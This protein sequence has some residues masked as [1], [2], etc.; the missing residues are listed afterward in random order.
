MS[1]SAAQSAQQTTLANLQTAFN[2][3]SNA[4]ARYGAFAVRAEA[5]GY[6]QVASLFRATSRAEQIHAAHHAK[7]IRSMGA[8]PVLTLE[9][10]DV[11]TTAENLKAAIA[12]EE[13]EHNVMYPE[14]IKQAEA[15]KD[16][17]AARTFKGAMAAE[18]EHAKLYKAALANLK[19]SAAKATYYVCPVCGFT[20]DKVT[21]DNCPV[22][23]V[24]GEKFEEIQ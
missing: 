23:K 3:E 5:E 7:V 4:C 20:V 24:P 15:V 2:G 18:I 13:Y 9:A 1:T 10:P 16:A 17:A 12:G 19:P 6:H 11:K 8:Q 21:F 14:F 22:C